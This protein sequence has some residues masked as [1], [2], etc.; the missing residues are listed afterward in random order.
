MTA[1]DFRVMVG[2][3]AANRPGPSL[4]G[5]SD[6]AL[7]ALLQHVPEALRDECRM[8]ERPDTAAEIAVDC[9]TS[10]VPLAMYLQYG[11]VAAMT[12]DYD[13]LVEVHTEATG[14]GCQSEAS[15]GPY[16]VDATEAG[17]LLCV[18]DDGVATLYW[19][20]ERSRIMGQARAVDGSFADLYAWWL[21]A[22]PLP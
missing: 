22:G 3:V 19:T 12:A 11:D 8:V 21:A 13:E 15:E 1:D 6:A 4:P 16:T 17:R 14:S 2:L 20:D 9:G 5:V 10:D 18:L 7:E